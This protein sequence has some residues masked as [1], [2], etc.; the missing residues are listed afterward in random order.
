LDLRLLDETDAGDCIWEGW[1]E[2]D[3][4]LFVAGTTCVESWERKLTFKWKDQLPTFSLVDEWYNYHY[5]FANND[6]DLTYLPKWVFLPDDLAKSEAI[7]AGLPS[8]K[9]ISAGLPA[10]VELENK[11][12]AFLETPPPCPDILKDTKGILVFFLLKHLFWTMGPH[13][14]N[15]DE[16]DHL[17]VTQRIPL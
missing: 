14:E 3:P 17:W 2:G 5:R 4:S 13:Q 6:G 16:W 12:N 1:K 8:D 11:R 10:L 9:C 7:T 15:Q